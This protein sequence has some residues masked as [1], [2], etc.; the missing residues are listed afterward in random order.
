[1]ST[2]YKEVTVAGRLMARRIMGK[3]SFA[4]IQDSS[5]RIQIYVSRDDIAPGEDKA[6]YN[7]LFKKLLDF[8]DF[9]G[10]TGH[11][12]KTRT[13][14]TS[15]HVKEFTFLGKSLRPLPVVKTDDDGNVHDEFTDPE[16]RYRQRYVD[17]VV[18]P[19][20][21]E[22]FLKRTKLVTAIRTFLDGMGMIEV[23]TPILQAIHGGAAARPFA[24][25]NSTWLIRTIT[26]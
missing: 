22:I 8:G 14:E 3:A 5:G 10:V 7:T 12:F 25:L 15:I 26:G 2:N 23:E 11:V 17:L 16:L 21:K 24:T 19:H 18:N 9:I 13:G 1:M 6:L 4:S 20:V